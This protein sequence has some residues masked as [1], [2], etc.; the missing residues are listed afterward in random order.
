MKGRPWKSAKIG[1]ARLNYA[2]FPHSDGLEGRAV[3][4]TMERANFNRDISLTPPESI[5]PIHCLGFDR[6]L[7]QLNLKAR[8]RLIVRTLAEVNNS[9]YTA[10]MTKEV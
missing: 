10:G 7:N 3:K 9:A 8:S 1:S 5:R 2:D 6:K 4:E